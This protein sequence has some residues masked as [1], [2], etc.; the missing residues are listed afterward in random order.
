MAEEWEQNV[1]WFTNRYNL[2][3][4]TQFIR[5]PAA[6]DNSSH[7]SCSSGGDHLNCEQGSADHTT[8]EADK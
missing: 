2:G 4:P 5:L 7:A 6:S 3:S 1:A 8:N